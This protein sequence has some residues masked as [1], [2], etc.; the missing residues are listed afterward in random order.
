MFVKWGSL[1]QMSIRL[2]IIKLVTIWKERSFI[3]NIYVLTIDF[4]RY[5]D[6]WYNLLHVH[7]T[8]YPDMMTWFH[9]TLKKAREDGEKVSLAKNKKKIISLWNLIQ[10]MDVILHQKEALSI[11]RPFFNDIM[12]LYTKRFHKVMSNSTLI[13]IRSSSCNLS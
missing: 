4:S 10:W 5:K 7:N 11:Q 9:D 13:L 1:F 12:S 8:L 2:Y 3:Y 6:N